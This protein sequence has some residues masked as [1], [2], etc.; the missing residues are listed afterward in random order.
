M[1]GAR[2]NKGKDAKDYVF[3]KAVMNFVIFLGTPVFDLFNV[4]Y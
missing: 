1:Q 4:K 3:W 2:I